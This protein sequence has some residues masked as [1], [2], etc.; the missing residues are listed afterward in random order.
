MC[1]VVYLTSRSFDKASFQFRNALAEELRSRGIEVVEESICKIKQLFLPH[2]TYGLA[3]AID[4]FRDD[5]NGCGL[6]V[7]RRGSIISK[8]FAHNLSN[9][10]DYLLPTVRWRSINFVDS[11][12]DDWNRFFNK[13]SA[14][15]KAILY[16]CTES[17]ETDW[18][19]YLVQFPKLVKNFADEIIRCLRSDYD[20]DKYIKASS[21]ARLKRKRNG[22]V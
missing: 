13:V 21:L 22:V 6:T 14:E 12:D 3:V 8:T 1:K 11:D 19:N 10:L 4:F 2:K 9:V 18:E 5:G 15:A 16:L 20:E 17:N 7:N